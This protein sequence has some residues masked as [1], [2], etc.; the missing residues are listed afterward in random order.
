MGEREG[1]SKGMVGFEEEQE[2]KN[3]KWGRGE[4]V[5]EPLHRLGLSQGNWTVECSSNS[6]WIST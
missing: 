5:T 1:G 2:R 4:G 3:E 6:L